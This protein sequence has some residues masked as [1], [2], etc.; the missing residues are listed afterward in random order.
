MRQIQ[1]GLFDPARLLTHVLS[2]LVEAH[3]VEH[4]MKKRR[5]ETIGA[6]QARPGRVPTRTA[7]EILKAAE[8]RWPARYY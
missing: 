4:V 2:R 1:L 6:R 3:T 8:R 5:T 7:G